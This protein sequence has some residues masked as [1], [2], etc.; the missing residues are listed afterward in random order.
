MVT[1]R[2]RISYKTSYY[3]IIVIHKNVA[4]FIFQWFL[5]NLEWEH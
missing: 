1:Q 5:G 2:K 3:Y 4:I